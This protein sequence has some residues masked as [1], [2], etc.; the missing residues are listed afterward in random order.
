MPVGERERFEFW[1][2]GKA[3]QLHAVKVVG[4]SIQ[5]VPWWN[6]P[7]CD[8]CRVTLARSAVDSVRVPKFDGNATGALASVAL[9]FLFIPGLAIMAMFILGLD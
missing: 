2:A 6:D 7:A 5:G 4:D 8:S 3:H 9:P 1:S